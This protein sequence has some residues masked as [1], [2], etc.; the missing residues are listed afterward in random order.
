VLMCRADFSDENVDDVNRLCRCVSG[1]LRE[2][3]ACG[4]RR[5]LV[6]CSSSNNVTGCSCSACAKLRL[7]METDWSSSHGDGDGDGAE[8]SYD[9]ALNASLEGLVSFGTDV[10]GGLREL[11]ASS[12][13]LAASNGRR[14]RLNVLVASFSH[15]SLMA[16]STPGDGEVK[17]SH[18]FHLVYDCLRRPG[19]AASGGSADG[20]GA[21]GMASLVWGELLV[22][23]KHVILSDVE[24]TDRV[25]ILEAVCREA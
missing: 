15:T 7:Q 12:R 14:R 16:P 6:V 10:G 3:V 17:A 1:F 22:E 9:R 20:N 24:E 11:L 2:L 19:G 8:W 5:V 4:L 18:P 25:D 13:F 23:T 21:L